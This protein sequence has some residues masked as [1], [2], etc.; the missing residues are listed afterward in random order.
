MV[1]SIIF[2]IVFC[3]QFFDN[4]IN[5]FLSNIPNFGSFGYLSTFEF[6]QDGYNFEHLEIWVCDIS[7]LFVKDIVGV[8][9]KQEG[10]ELAQ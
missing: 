5:I 9:Y 6:L 2:G 1:K 4:I 3:F 7:F 10:I 8:V